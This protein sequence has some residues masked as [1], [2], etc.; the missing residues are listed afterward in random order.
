MMQRPNIL[1]LLADQLR[2]DALGA[3]GN[4]DA[5][6]PTMDALARGG[7]RFANACSTSPICV[8]FRFSLMTGE[9]AHTRKV[10]G[11]E[12]AM[13][14]AERTL[15][16]E[17]N[18]AGYETFYVGKWHLDG[19]HGRLGSAQQCGRMRVPRSRQGRWQT[20]CGFELRNDPLDTWVFE[21]DNPVPRKVDGYQ[22]DGLFELG[23]DYLAKRKTDAPPFCMVISVE[24]PHDPFVAPSGLE[25]IW[26]EREPA[27][28]P[29]FA[30]EDPERRQQVVMD[31]K[32]YYAMIENFDQNVERMVAFLKKRGLWENTVVIVVADHGELGGA[33]GLVAKQWPYEESIGIPLIVHAPGSEAARGSVIEEPVCTEDLFPTILG[34]AGLTPRNR[35]PGLN[36]APVIAGQSTFPTREGILLE[37]VAELRPQMP[38][39]SDPWRGFRSRRYKYT[40]KGDFH[41]AKP[42]QFFDLEADPFEMENRLND[43]SLAAEVARHHRL[44]RERIHET[45][46]AFALLPAF[47]CHSLNLWNDLH[48]EAEAEIES[49]TSS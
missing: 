25:E 3:Y 4:Q 28:P 35:L 48:H 1:I 42:W 29:N 10:P 37:F 13:S 23:M 46:D 7:V 12:Y 41:G 18:D 21:N 43:P 34:L 24:P 36:L 31:R 22:T 32:L 15:A 47:G 2:R 9:Y 17:F 49:P 30:I 16:D 8:P 6:T 19:A 26:K 14:E 33:H 27:L 11:I 40:V 5:R 39:H 38:F 20:W 45:D 44:L